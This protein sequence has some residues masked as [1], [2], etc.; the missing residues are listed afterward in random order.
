MQP[1]GVS[2]TVT[3]SDRWPYIKIQT[4]RGKNPTEI[5]GALSEVCGEFTVD[6]STVS[7]WANRFRGRCMSI[8]NDPRPGRP[9]TSRDQR[10]VKLVAELLKKIVVQHVKNFLKLREQKLRRKMH[11][12]RP[13]LL[14]AGP[15]VLHANARPH[16]ADFITKNFA[17]MSGKCYLMRPTAQT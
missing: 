4:L 14:V 13:Q 6:R 16:I 10:S 17:I 7:R 8:D 12:N 5:H 3:I 11:R 1:A 9:R 2:G 15:L